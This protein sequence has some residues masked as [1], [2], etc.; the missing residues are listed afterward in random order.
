MKGLVIVAALL[1]GGASLALAQG[2]PTGSYPPVAGGAAGN[3]ATNP[4][5]P[6]PPG[7][8]VIPGGPAQSAATTPSRTRV[9]HHPRH[10]NM[11]MQ[12]DIHRG[13]KVTG[14]A[15]STRKFLHNQNSYR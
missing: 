7:P 8:G 1:L 15:L 12:G 11:Y 6:G 4:V 5:T 2:Q 14:S 13:S 3:P 9:A 10:R